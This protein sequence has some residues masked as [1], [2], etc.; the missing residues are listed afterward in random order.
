HV[1][2]ATLVLL[3]AIR[4]LKDGRLRD[5][6]VGVLA[7]TL[8]LA[9]HLTIVL[10]TPALLLLCGR[11]L[12][13]DP[14]RGRRLSLL[15]SLL[16]V[17]PSLYLLLLMWARAE[18]LHAWGHTVSLPLLWNHASA[19]IFRIFMHRPDGS[20]LL[21]VWKQASALFQDNFPYLTSVL[22]VVGG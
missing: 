8:G 2:L 12:W 9:H 6:V 16:P 7:L 15:L 22:P 5:L 17:G 4:Y 11:R 1:L 19:R 21:R 10:L 13:L 3:H 20:D 14:G 18:P